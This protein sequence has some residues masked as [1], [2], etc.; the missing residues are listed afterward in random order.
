[1]C[2]ISYTH[3]TLFFLCSINYYVQ[4]WVMRF[5]V[6]QLFLKATINDLQKCTFHEGCPK[7]KL[8]LLQY[9]T[10]STGN[11]I[12][13][14]LSK[15]LFDFCIF[16]K[17]VLPCALKGLYCTL[18]NQEKKMS[19]LHK[20]CFF[21]LNFSRKTTKKGEREKSCLFS[22]IGFILIT[23][24]YPHFKKSLLILILLSPCISED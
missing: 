23:Q 20:A 24:C 8:L 22:K 3:D 2:K 18:K 4:T 5:R 7:K 21:L 16:L 14:F 9:K 13:L 19:L 10:E 1:M 12:S 17:M 6:E 11:F 15:I